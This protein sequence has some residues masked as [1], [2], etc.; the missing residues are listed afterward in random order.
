MPMSDCRHCDTRITTLGAGWAHLDPGAEE[1]H[2]P[3]PP[4]NHT[5]HKTQ[6]QGVEKDRYGPRWP[7]RI[8]KIQLPQNFWERPVVQEPMDR[9]PRWRRRR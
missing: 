2:N 9:K 4:L 6:V 7:Q 1:D 3:E 8:A 5:W